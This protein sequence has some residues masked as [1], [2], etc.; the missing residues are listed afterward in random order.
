M[1]TKAVEVKPDVL[2]HSYFESFC[3][4][5]F[6]HGF[7]PAGFNFYPINGQ[8]RTISNLDACYFVQRVS[9]YGS[10]DRG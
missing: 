6:G 1:S 3:D 9:E 7:D 10:S 2:G 5:Q 4:K 8:S